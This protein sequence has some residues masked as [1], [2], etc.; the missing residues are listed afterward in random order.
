MR[1]H[2][3]FVLQRRRA[4][5]SSREAP[6]DLRPPRVRLGLLAQLLALGHV[7]H[8]AEEAGGAPVLVERAPTAREDPARTPLEIKAKDDF[9]GAL[10]R[11]IERVIHAGLDGRPIVGMDALEEALERGRLRAIDVP[12]R[13]NPLVPQEP[14]ARGMPLPDPDVARGE[15]EQQP[16]FHR[17]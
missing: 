2:A 16:L 3:V 7:E 9:E 13:V 4:E 8:G 6:P 12:E 11:G 1:S 10:E 14:P 5:Q 15:R 17:S